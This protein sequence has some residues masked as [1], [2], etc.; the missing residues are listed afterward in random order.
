MGRVLNLEDSLPPSPQ[1]LRKPGKTEKT[2][3]KFGLEG[4][5]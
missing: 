3:A 2:Y 5:L 1:D 4:V